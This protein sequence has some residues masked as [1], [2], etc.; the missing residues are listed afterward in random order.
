LITVRL[1]ILSLQHILVRAVA[2]LTT[3]GERQLLPLKG[4]DTY[5][6]HRKELEYVE[7]DL[8]NA[9]G[10]LGDI[11]DDASG[12]TV[13]IVLRAAMDVAFRPSAPQLSRGL[14]AIISEYSEESHDGI[15]YILK[16]RQIEESMTPT[17]NNIQEMISTRNRFISSID[18]VLGWRD[19]A[20]GGF[21]AFDDTQLF[22]PAALFMIPA[23]VEA[24][25]RDG[26]PDCLGRPVGHMLHDNGVAGEYQVSVTNYHDDYYDSD[27]LGR[28][29]LHIVCA[30][31]EHEH[32]FIGKAND[33]IDIDD[34]L[35]H[36]KM[37]GLSPFDVAAIHGNTYIFGSV[38]AS[39]YFT[40]TDLALPSS[41]TLRTC[42]HWAAGFGHIDLLRYLLLW[43]QAEGSHVLNKVL[44]ATD[45][46]NDIAMHL[47][48]RKG[49]TDVVTALLEY[50][51]WNDMRQ[52]F[53]WHTPFW[54]AVAGR[55]FD[56]ME[57]L[58]PHSNIDNADRHNMTPLAEAARQGY[59]EGVN[60]LRGRRGVDMNFVNRSL[61]EGRYVWMTPLDFAMAGEHTRCI[62]MLKESGALTGREIIIREQKRCEERE[63]ETLTRLV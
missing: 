5:D 37:L 26:R 12:A 32:D 4:S 27:L 15:V 53:W 61:V 60:Y 57:L 2:E 23:I 11:L 31:A 45:F 3:I 51:D 63:H 36:L 54:S 18:D 59:I 50:T 24:V 35:I 58:T 29:S 41:C 21:S 25:Q 22:T 46:Q 33:R 40:T 56:I 1:V 10:D 20:L 49:H 6:R 42:L 44:R 19:V 8:C 43:F 62:E 28:T 13:K 17:D 9:I 16:M 48:A 39:N 55:H 34:S 52:I 14:D 30:M 38:L 7:N 47:A